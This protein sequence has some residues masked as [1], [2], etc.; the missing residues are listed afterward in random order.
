MLLCIATGA[1]T[2]HTGV[3]Q[4]RS[5]SFYMLHLRDK[6]R[7]NLRARE[8]I[9]S[10]L[11]FFQPWAGRQPLTVATVA[12]PPAQPWQQ[13]PS[14]PPVS[15]LCL[16][17]PAGCWAWGFPSTAGGFDM[18][19]ESRWK[20][21]LLEDKRGGYRGKGD[22]YRIWERLGEMWVE[23]GER[24]RRWSQ[25]YRSWQLCPQKP[26]SRWLHYT[27]SLLLIV[28]STIPH[29]CPASCSGTE[30]P[31][32]QLPS[33]SHPSFH[34]QFQL[35]APLPCLRRALASGILLHPFRSCFTLLWLKMCILISTLNL[36]S[37]IFIS[38]YYPALICYRVL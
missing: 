30:L 9:I 31:E 6:R 38:F 11:W 29:P 12:I 10:T 33:P 37:F 16:K 18:L 21:E 2:A 27:S 5:W 34:L 36:S 19:E 23:D 13:T 8:Q 32:A 25:G 24:N 17:F 26:P 4:G 20:R 28:S 22:S 14:A 1:H 15:C 3:N 35:L 7:E